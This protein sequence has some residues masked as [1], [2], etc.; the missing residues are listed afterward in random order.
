MTSRRGPEPLKGKTGRPQCL[1]PIGHATG[2][3][4]VW[5]KPEQPGPATGGVVSLEH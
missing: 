4:A 5:H 1:A 2:T 3:A